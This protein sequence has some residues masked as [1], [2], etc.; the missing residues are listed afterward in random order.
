MEF[1]S[2]IEVC[3]KHYNHL[4]NCAKAIDSSPKHVT[5]DEYTN[6]NCIMEMRNRYENK[7]LDL[8]AEYCEKL[9]VDAEHFYHAAEAIEA[10]DENERKNERQNMRLLWESGR[11]QAFGRQE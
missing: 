2:N 5:F 11:N 9:R 4:L 8:L 3:E 7:L 1:K 10:F 6:F